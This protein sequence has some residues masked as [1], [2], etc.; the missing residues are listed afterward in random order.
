MCFLDNGHNTRRH[1]EKTDSCILNDI[2]GY[3]LVYLKKYIIIRVPWKFDLALT[4]SGV[5]NS[6]TK[7]DNLKF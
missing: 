3:K 7:N 1:F 6:K 4:K 5:T 2:N